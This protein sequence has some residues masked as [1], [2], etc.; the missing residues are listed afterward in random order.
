MEKMSAYERAKKVYEQIQEQKKRENAARLLER[1]RRQ[2]VLEKY[3]R[4]KKQMNKALR[5]C[6]RK[7]QPN[8]GAQMEVLLKKI[9]NSDRK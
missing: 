7:G 6:N 1:E 2:A 9:E 3:M 5:K 4:S 8:L